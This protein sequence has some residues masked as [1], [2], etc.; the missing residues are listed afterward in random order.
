MS[1][2]DDRV[3][4]EQ[5]YSRTMEM[6]SPAMLPLASPLSWRAD[7]WLVSLSTVIPAGEQQ[8]VGANSATTLP[9]PHPYANVD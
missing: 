7:R 4:L 5:L 1:I 3:G 6:Y 2:A 8:D 9:S